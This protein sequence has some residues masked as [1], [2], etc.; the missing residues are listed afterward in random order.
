MFQPIV[1]MVGSGGTKLHLTR[2][3]AGFCAHGVSSS[4]TGTIAATEA[5]SAAAEGGGAQGAMGGPSVGGVAAAAS[6]ALEAQSEADDLRRQLKEATTRKERLTTVFNKQIKEFREVVIQLTGY[7]V[8][9]EVLKNQVTLYPPYTAHD[10]TL[11][12]ETGR[13]TNGKIQS[14]SLVETAFYKTLPPA[15]TSHMADGHLSAFLAAI[16]LAL[17][18]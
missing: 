3:C 7:R 10:A 9:L 15:I 14:L 11:V 2:C 1:E 6:A 13:G 16:T 8:D 4:S 18:P 12:F 5:S 17:K